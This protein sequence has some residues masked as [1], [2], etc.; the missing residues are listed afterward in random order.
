MGSY[1]QAQVTAFTV[2]E[3]GPNNEN[4]ATRIMLVLINDQ[5]Y[6]HEADVYSDTDLPSTDGY[7]FTSILSKVQE[8]ESE[9]EITVKPE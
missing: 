2:G 3:F 8:G 7:L 1:K 9:K 6:R 5:M 4:K